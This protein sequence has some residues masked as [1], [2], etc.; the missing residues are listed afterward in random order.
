MPY[1][2]NYHTGEFSLKRGD[3]HPQ[4]REAG[5]TNPPCHDPI[6]VRLIRIRFFSWVVIAIENEKHENAH[7]VSAASHESPAEFHVRLIRGLMKKTVT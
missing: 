2:I 1:L 5:G 6:K 3:P 7:A 4:G